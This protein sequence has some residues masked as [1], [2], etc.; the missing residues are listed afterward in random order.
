MWYNMFYVDRGDLPEIF[1]VFFDVFYPDSTNYEIYKN[2]AT[3]GND[4]FIYGPA[5][6]PGNSVSVIY[7][8]SLTFL[9][10]FKDYAASIGVD[11]HY[12]TMRKTQ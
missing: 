5:H 7:C 4:K 2:G 8:T 3:F 6:G 11:Y 12:T 10:E 9:E 1:K